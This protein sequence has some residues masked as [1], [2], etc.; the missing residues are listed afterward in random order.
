M[1]LGLDLATIISKLARKK[2][3]GDKHSSLFFPPSVTTKKKFNDLDPW[4][5]IGQDIVSILARK[6]E[7]DFQISS[8]VASRN[9]IFETRQVNP[10]P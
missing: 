7:E 3:A 8:E 1:F 6:L 2:I 10:T 4:T 5:L 9:Y